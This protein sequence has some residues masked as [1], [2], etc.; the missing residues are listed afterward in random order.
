M[1][2]AFGT[3]SDADQKDE[4]LYHFYNELD[5]Q[6]QQFLRPHPLPLVIAGVDYEIAL[7]HSVSEYTN[8][9]PGGV[10]GAADGLK[11]GELHARAL[12]VVQS[13]L[14]ARVEKALGQYEKA[15]G[16]RI[17]SSVPEIV[18]AAYDGRILQLFLAEGGRMAGSYDLATR[19]VCQTDGAMNDL[20]ELAA[21]QTVAHAGDV[22]I[23]PQE[24]VPGGGLAAATLRF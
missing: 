15:G 6:L 7:Y 9:A 20:L 24:R 17:R 22:L 23:L 16:D 10:Q 5:K 19:T 18:E 21:L 14:E 11:G 1:I 12:T 3:S 2:V 13:L 4:Y 8:L